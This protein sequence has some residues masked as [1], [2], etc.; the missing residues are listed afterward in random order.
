MTQRKEEK[1]NEEE[2]KNAYQKG[3]D[4]WS[5]EI[6]ASNLHQCQKLLF[7]KTIFYLRKTKITKLQQRYK[8]KKMMKM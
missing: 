1:K 5:N 2:K 8:V 7:A 4:D 3:L 6:T